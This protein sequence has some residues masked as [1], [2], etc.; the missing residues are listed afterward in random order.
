MVNQIEKFHKAFMA[1]LEPY[2]NKRNYR[3]LCLSLL[4]IEKPFVM[5]IKRNWQK[6]T[7]GEIWHDSSELP[8]EEKWIL[9]CDTF[10]EY[11]A[12]AWANDGNGWESSY[13]VDVEGLGVVNLP[14]GLRGKITKWAY[15]DDLL[16]IKK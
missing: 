6:Q 9:M 16:T 11:M 12:G 14:L 4:C 7:D 13:N 1:V 15:I 5:F 10:G 8:T 2:M 3:T